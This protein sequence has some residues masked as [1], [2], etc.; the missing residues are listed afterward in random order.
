MNV[1]DLPLGVSAIDQLVVR[2]DVSKDHLD[3]YAIHV[4]R[5]A[6]DREITVLLDRKADRIEEQLDELDD[7]ADRHD[8]SGLCV[9]CEPTGGYDEKLLRLPRQQDHETAYVNTEL[10]AKMS[11]VESEDTGRRAPDLDRHH[12]RATWPANRSQ[13]EAEKDLHR[14]DKVR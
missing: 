9:V 2:F 7:Y 13:T 4:R 12:F 6:V 10:T 5:G 8:L 3:G 11:T 14:V 1:Q